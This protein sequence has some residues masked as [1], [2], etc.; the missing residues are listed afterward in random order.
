MGETLLQSGPSSYEKVAVCYFRALK[1]YPDPMNL[2]MA[3]EQSLPQTV[4]EMIMK[5]MAKEADGG[6]KI[7]EVDIEL[8]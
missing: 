6:Q 4:M 3:L 1:V 7:S 5:M 8:E 2:I